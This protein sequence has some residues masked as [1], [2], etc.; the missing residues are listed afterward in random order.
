MEKKWIV[1]LGGRKDLLPDKCKHAP[2]PVSTR[3]NQDGSLARM[4]LLSV[5]QRLVRWRSVGKKITTYINM[6]TSRSSQLLLTNFSGACCKISDESIK[7][8]LTVTES[9]RDAQMPRAV[10]RDWWPRCYQGKV[11]ETWHEQV[12]GFAVLFT[13]RPSRRAAGQRKSRYQRRAVYVCKWERSATNCRPIW[14]GQLRLPVECEQQYWIDFKQDIKDS[15]NFSS[16]TILVTM[17]TAEY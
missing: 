4:Q 8:R 14:F 9:A 15:F 17:Q 10:R 11:A 5:A 13:F 2:R 1:R 12:T 7:M 3:Q 16:F 6:E